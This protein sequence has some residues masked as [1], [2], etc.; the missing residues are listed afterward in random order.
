[1]ILVAILSSRGSRTR[2]SAI[3][4]TSGKVAAPRRAVRATT[5]PQVVQA[6]ILDL[7]DHRY[8]PL[9]L[10]LLHEHA[11]Q[12]HFEIWNSLGPKDAAPRTWRRELAADHGFRG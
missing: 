11:F 7:N 1:M 6:E 8:E 2:T 3:N 12:R 4:C 9:P 10:T 5:V